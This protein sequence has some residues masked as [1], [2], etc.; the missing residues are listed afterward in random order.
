MAALFGSQVRRLWMAPG[1]TQVEL[2]AKTHV[3]GS[4]ITQIERALGAKPTF[5]LTQRLDT[6]LG[7]DNLLIDMWPYVYREAFPDWSRAFMAYSER[8]VSIRQ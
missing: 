4:R 3:V 5:E 7:A 8:T 6:V 1:L 2:G